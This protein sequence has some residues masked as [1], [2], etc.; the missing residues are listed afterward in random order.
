LGFS[1]FGAVAA[2]AAHAVASGPFRRVDGL[3][4]VVD[5]RIDVRRLVVNGGD[6]DAYGQVDRCVA[7]TRIDGDRIYGLTEALGAAAGLF[8]VAVQQPE[9]ELLSA[10]APENIRGPH[11]LTDHG[12]GVFESFVAHVV[13]VVVVDTLEMIDVEKQQRE[14]FA[15][16][17]AAL[18]QVGQLVDEGG[19]VCDAGQRVLGRHLPQLG[20]GAV[21]FLL[22]LA[23]RVQV[24]VAGD[25]AADGAEQ[26]FQ[27]VCALFV[28]TPRPVGY[29]GHA[30]RLVAGVQRQPQVS[31]QGRVAFG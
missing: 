30:D 15:V 25:E 16:P 12:D 6:A 26:R 17:L 24:L 1:G 14:I 2:E 20:L 9:Q 3:V 22:C 18:E 4:G 7:I 13:A 8:R 5:E 19:A 28:L 31:V 27:Q 29:A 10:L 11:V 23:A 21:Q